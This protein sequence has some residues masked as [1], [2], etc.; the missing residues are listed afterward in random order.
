MQSTK[1]PSTIKKL[2]LS[3]QKMFKDTFTKVHQDSHSEAKAFAIAWGAIKTRLQPSEGKFIALSDA[4]VEER[5]FEFPVIS[6][7]QNTFVMN[8]VGDEIEFE[9]IL[10]STGYFI[11]GDLQRLRFSEEALKE[12]AE[13]INKNGSTLPDFDHKAAINAYKNYGKNEQLI[14][15][16]LKEQ[17]GLIKSIQAVYKDGKLWIKGVLSSAYKK[18]M[19]Q[20]RGMSIEAITRKIDGDLIKK[21]A[22]MG[23]TFALKSKPQLP[24]AIIT[25]VSA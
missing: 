11:S 21:S 7:G 12:L 9:G 22:Y 1:T 25:R 17:K 13:D 8:A 19:H 24:D 15:N 3:A 23:F 10:A 16:S 14:L 6:E 4:F 20:V 18:V 2:P 5:M